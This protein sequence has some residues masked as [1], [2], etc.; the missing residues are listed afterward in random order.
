MKE[1]QILDKFKE[2]SQIPHCS[3][4]TKELRDFL[5]NYA[6]NHGYSVDVDEVGNI[7]AIKGEPKIC[8]QSHY[9]MV[10]VGHTPKLELV[11]KDGFLSAKE[12]SLGADNGMGVAI[13]MQMM[14]EFENLEC[15]F[16]NDEE[17]GLIGANGFDGNFAS[18]KLLNLDSE[19]DSE[20]IVGCAGGINIF[21][22]IDADTKTVSSG[23]VYEVIVSGYPGGHSG[24][25][26]QKDIP[27]AIKILARFIRQNGAKLVSIE[28]G[29]RSNSIPVNAKAVVVSQ[30]KLKS[31]DLHICVKKLDGT[32]KILKNSDQILAFINGFSQ[33]VRSY[34]VE[35][36]LPKD[37][38]NLSTVKNHNG[39]TW[40]EFYARSMS[41]DGIS[42]LEFEI[43]EMA[44]A[45]GFDI[46]INERSNPWEPSA[47]EFAYAVLDELQ[48]FKPDAKI[49]A[50]HAGLECGVLCEGRDDMQTCSI[51]PNIYSPHSTHERCELASVDII[52]S[53][54]RNIIS[55]Y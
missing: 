23:D 50:I 39:K 34:D 15:L 52:A 41:M 32:A 6:K 22:C 51:G 11:E 8:L 2:I 3:F 49:K 18:K 42:R 44:S 55:R 48:K 16:T 26:I 7:H 17:I 19:D 53:V 35:L 31:D 12:S 28:G 30:N 5:A 29:E 13:M 40:V 24:V 4:N 33:G 54:V 21:A 1:V 9:D 47:D 38:V 45:L 25:E 37:S 20:V 14:K 10:C 27:N 36:N 46:S 43:G